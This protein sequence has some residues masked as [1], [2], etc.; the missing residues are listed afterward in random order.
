MRVK[1][2]ACG[3]VA[4]EYRAEVA[5]ESSGWT[6][7]AELEVP[8]ATS[9]PCT[10]DGVLDIPRARDFPTHTG[11]VLVGARSALGRVMRTSGSDW[12]VATGGLR[13]ARAGRPSSGSR[14]ICCW[15]PTS[16]HLARRPG[17]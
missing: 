17:R 2:S 4:E 1:A 16:D 11:L 7:M 15:I 13:A 6:G 8:T 10:E 9:T 12:S 3:L 14:W 5:L